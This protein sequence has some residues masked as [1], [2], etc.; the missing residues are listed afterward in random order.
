MSVLKISNAFHKA[1]PLIDKLVDT[2]IGNGWKYLPDDLQAQNSRYKF[3][4]SN[5]LHPRLAEDRLDTD[6][7]GRYQVEDSEYD[8]PG[9]RILYAPSII[10]AA[11]LL[12]RHLPNLSTTTISDS[13]TAIVALHE[14]VHWI[15]HSFTSPSGNR[16]AKEGLFDESS[17][18][19]DEGLA[20]LFTQKMI[21]NDP[22]LLEV[23]NEL[24]KHQPKEY[25]V[26]RQCEQYDLIKIIDQLADPLIL[27]SQSWELLVEC[28]AE[29]NKDIAIKNYVEKTKSDDTYERFR[30]VLRIHRPD[31]SDGPHNS[32]AYRGRIIAKAFGM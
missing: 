19:F 12:Q 27:R 6:R 22:V 24:C 16:I 2:F 4:Y 31:L 17:L 14:T 8:E 7:L 5:L 32:G 29:T 26:Y 21:T 15:M 28:M 11:E 23:F 18:L 9:R 13:L 30:I 1:K 20:Q 3:D 25:T 10:R